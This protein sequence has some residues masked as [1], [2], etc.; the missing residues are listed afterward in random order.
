MNLT[1]TSQA[2]KAKTIRLAYPANFAGIGCYEERNT[3][4]S[5]NWGKFNISDLWFEGVCICHTA[6]KPKQPCAVNLQ[7]DSFCWIMNFVLKGELNARF[8]GV[9]Q[10]SLKDGSHHTFF[11]RS[12]NTDLVFEQ[13]AN[14]FT[15]CLTRKFISK[16]IGKELL[17]DKPDTN[18]GK[19][20][21]LVTNGNY[22]HTR[23]HAIIKEIIEAEQTGYIRRIFLES[24][25]LELLSLQLQQ[26]DSDKAPTKG[27]N[28]EDIARL[29]EAKA[30]I[31]QNMQTPCSLIELARKTG[32]NDFKLKKGFKAL[33]GNT[34]FGYL[35]NVRMDSAHT[36]L[37]DDK[38]VSEVAELIGYKNPHHFT[39]AFKRKFGFLP[40]Q[41]N[42][43][44]V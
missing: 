26:A 32:L 40:S 41:V 3:A 25:I 5:E 20:F 27:F 21:T 15:I 43:M 9:K 11:T 1:F 39:A 31:N 13:H 33:F 37:Q 10:L 34:V 6:I 14:I 17:K 35:Y 22:R 18:A 19:T 42:K 8:D 38:S 23:P 30:Y 4:L 28:R 36:L 24:K 12:L 16:L 7:C 29:Q 44:Q 2:S